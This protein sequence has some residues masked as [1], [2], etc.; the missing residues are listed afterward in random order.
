MRE[1]NQPDLLDNWRT[2][3]SDR[4]FIAQA[5]FTILFMVLLLVFTM[6]YFEYIQARPGKYLADPILK[7]IPPRNL[8][9]YT[10]IVLYS[11]LI[12]AFY[13]LVDKPR[14]LFQAF[15]IYCLIIVSRII[16]LYLVPLEPSNEMIPL[17]DPLVDYF[18]YKDQM[19]S[20]DLFFSGHVSTVFLAVLMVKGFWQ[21]TVLLIATI[22]IAVMIL[23]QHV[24]YTID[25]IAAPI[26]T[27]A[28]YYVVK[29]LYQKYYDWF[30]AVGG[31]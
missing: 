25:I 21:K 27:F 16:T 28:C 26:F 22:A 8:S 9:I 2:V 31:A 1:H 18:I 23:V 30:G 29:K 15:Q 13:Q 10:F 4:F 3:L 19:I 24:H 7:R 11:S 17:R 20:K 12:F 14:L 6:N 5:L